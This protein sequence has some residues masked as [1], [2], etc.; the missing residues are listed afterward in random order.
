MKLITI[1]WDYGCC[2][3]IQPFIYI[4]TKELF[5]SIAGPFGRQLYEKLYKFGRDWYQCLISQH[6]NL[7]DNFT[8]DFFYSNSCAYMLWLSNIHI[9]R[10]PLVFYN[11]IYW[12][13]SSDRCCQFLA[14]F[15]PFFS[16][17]QPFSWTSEW[18]SWLD[19]ISMNSRWTSDNET[20]RWMTGIKYLIKKRSRFYSAGHPIIHSL[21]NNARANITMSWIVQ[22]QQH[23]RT[24]YRL[25]IFI[26]FSNQV[27]SW[28]CSLNSALM[29]SETMCWRSNLSC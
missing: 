7:P 11:K 8:S 26:Q 21:S 16:F 20:F 10:P 15:M 12:P 2:N 19:K 29:K 28:S 1:W 9:C 18:E 23:R 24:I 25:F 27:F 3:E 4:W 13:E 22:N 14:D 17:M 5:L 6:R